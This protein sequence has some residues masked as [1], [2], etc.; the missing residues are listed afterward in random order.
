MP[1]RKDIRTLALTLFQ[2]GIQNASEA[3]RICGVND[4]TMRRHFAKLR[5]GEG[6]DE[7]R[8][9]GRPRK[10]TAGLQRSLTQIK[11]RNPSASGQTLADRVS[12]TTQRPV[13]ARTVRRALHLMG[14]RWRV[15]QRR[16]LRPD[17]K[18]QRLRWCLAHQDDNWEHTI[19]S[20]ECTF[21]LHRNHNKLWVRSD[22]QDP[23]ETLPEAPYL[24]RRQEEVS[25]TV[26]AAIG[27]GKKAAL[28]FLPKN[29]NAGQLVQVF[30]RDV[31]PTLNWRRTRRQSNRLLIDNDGR[32]HTRIWKDYLE[33]N[34]IECVPDWPSNSPDLNPIENAFSWL[35]RHVEGQSPLSEDELVEAIHEAWDALPL[36]MTVTL[37]DSIPARIRQCIQRGGARTKY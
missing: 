20:D 31:F 9:S 13:S 32:H 36:E 23:R 18:A 1:S 19:S 3:A 22:P 12:A 11:R 28:G 24:T 17:Q 6:L 27:R 25:V 29:W 37:M 35:K 2:Q 4:R 7:K 14:F 15:A 21:N 10:I 30:S 8:R 33:E 16:R 26:F 34:Q 5:T